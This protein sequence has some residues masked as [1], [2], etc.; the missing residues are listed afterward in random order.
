MIFE[1]TPQ[2]CWT[3][4]KREKNCYFIKRFREA[5]NIY[6]TLKRAY[7]DV[8]KNDGYLICEHWVRH[9]KERRK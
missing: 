7:P 6:E 2:N 1:E 4:K 5:N 8:V 3:C 9:R